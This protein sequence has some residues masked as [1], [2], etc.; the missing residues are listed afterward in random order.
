MEYKAGFHFDHLWLFV[1][2]CNLAGNVDLFAQ[3]NT[4]PLPVAVDQ[5]WSDIS[6]FD[7]DAFINA[8]ISRN[9]KAPHFN[10]SFASAPIRRAFDTW[11]IFLAKA[12]RCIFD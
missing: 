2:S 7:L 6:N 12:V 9:Y 3:I 4:L 8:V 10:R 11:M 1:T 5:L